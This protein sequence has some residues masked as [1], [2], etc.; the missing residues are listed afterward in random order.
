[1]RIEQ[2]G[3]PRRGDAARL[4][5]PRQRE[6]LH[7]SQPALSEAI[8]KARARAPGHPARPAPL[9]RPDQPRGP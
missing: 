6:S 7:L 4:A 8:T 9:R 3:V 1:M 2:P 5:P